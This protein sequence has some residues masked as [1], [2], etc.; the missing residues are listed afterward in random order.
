[1]SHFFEQIDRITEDAE[2]ASIIISILL[3]VLIIS[4]IALN[5]ITC[6]CAISAKKSLK[7]IADKNLSKKEIEK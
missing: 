6:I 2:W 5:I 3:I 4:F 7:K 1:M